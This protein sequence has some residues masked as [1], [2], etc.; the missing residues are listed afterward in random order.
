M[1]VDP[2]GKIIILSNK[3]ENIDAEVKKLF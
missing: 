2:G 1:L 3:V